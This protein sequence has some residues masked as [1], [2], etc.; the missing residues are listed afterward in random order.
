MAHWATDM[1]KLEGIPQVVSSAP[2]SEP[3]FRGFGFECLCRIVADGDEDD[4][5]GVSTALLEYCPAQL[6][7][8]N[9]FLQ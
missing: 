7:D 4:P 1:A 8:V 5:E 6:S 9:S 2:M 3:L